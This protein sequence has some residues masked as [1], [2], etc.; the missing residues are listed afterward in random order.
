M[1][2]LFALWFFLPAGV[3][4]AAPVLINKIPFVTRWN[5]P[6]D[7]GKSFRGIRILGNNKTI[8]GV[9]CGALIA[10]GVGHGQQLL[11]PADFP[12]MSF[13]IGVA[14]G[15]GALLGDALESFFK[16]QKGVASGEKWFP[17]D[18][19]DYILGGI[20]FALPFAELTLILCAQI[21]II[22]FGMHLLF[23]Y[24]GYKLGLKNA[25]I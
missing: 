21:V 16:R 9:V 17:F 10:G 24:I 15:A 14:L 1:S 18:Q 12:E 7:F 8:R 20:V 23:A 3:A 22:W 2:W 6:L 19:I 11:A 25:P 4:N 13:I 5:T